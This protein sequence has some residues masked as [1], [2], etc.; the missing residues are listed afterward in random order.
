MKNT[1]FIITIAPWSNE[2][3]HNSHSKKDIATFACL[4]AKPVM[5]E[6]YLYLNSFRAI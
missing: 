6:N 5:H 4:L 2:R 3:A 1:I